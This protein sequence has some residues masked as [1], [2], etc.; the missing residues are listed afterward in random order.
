MKKELSP[1]EE[2]ERAARADA[3]AR[4]NFRKAILDHQVQNLA[5]KFIEALTALNNLNLIVTDWQIE[6][7]KITHVEFQ[8]DASGD[9]IWIELAPLFGEKG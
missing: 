8:D 2:G 4:K 1:A 3:K 5:R 7:S 9:K 6:D